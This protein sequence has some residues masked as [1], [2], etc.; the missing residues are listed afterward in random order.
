MIPTVKVFLASVGLALVMMGGVAVPF[1]SA[2]QCTVTAILLDGT[3]VTFTV[4]AP[5]GTPPSAMLPPGTPPVQSVIASCRAMTA[6]AGLSAPPTTATTVTTAG[7]NTTAH[8]SSPTH[9]TPTTATHSSPSSN[10]ATDHK[11]K[12]ASSGLAH[13]VGSPGRN[14][15]AIKVTAAAQVAT[16]RKLQRHP[17]GQTHGSTHR[18]G[19]APR[20]SLQSDRPRHRP[21]SALRAKRQR[22]AAAVETV[23]KEPALGP[24]KEVAPGPAHQQG[25]SPI[26]WMLLAG[27]ALTATGLGAAREV[28]LIR[29]RV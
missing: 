6:P 5:P 14:A 15:K 8:S 25:S 10:G 22:V 13:L 21:L 12:T 11:T 29:R 4:S 17:A 1:A 27:L 16:R 18:P 23:A 3:T 28:G 2:D 19:R 9:T 24:V 26:A 20:R 7:E